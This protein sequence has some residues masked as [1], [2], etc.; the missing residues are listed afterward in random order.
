MSN[1]MT[2]SATAQIEDKFVYG[3]EGIMNLF[4]CS[5]SKAIQLK[6]TTISKA[7]YQD[8]RKIIVDWRL[9]MDLVKANST[10]STNEQ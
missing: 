2:Q 5:R 9:A 3:L 1:S 8:G 6:K 7:V 10:T 4:K